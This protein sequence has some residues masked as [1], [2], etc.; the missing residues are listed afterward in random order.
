MLVQELKRIFE[1]RKIEMNAR[2]IPDDIK[3]L[4]VIHPRDMLEDTEYAIDQFVLRGGKLIAF[5]DPYAYFDQQPDMQNPFGGNQAGPVHVLQPVQGLGHRRRTWARS[6]RISPIASGAG[7]RLLPTLLNLNNQAL[8]M[9]DVVTSQVGTLLIPF[10]GAFKGK[11]A[12]G[13]T[14]DGARRTLRRTRCRWTSSSPRC[15]ASPRRAASSPPARRCR[16]RSGSPA[17]SSTAFPEG[18]PQAADA[19]R[20]EGCEEGRRE[21][22]GGRAAPQGSPPRRTRWCW[23]PTWTCSPTARRSRCRTYSGSAWS[24]PRNGNLAFAQGLVEQFSGDNALISL[25]SRAS[26]SRPLTLIREMEDRAQQSYLGKIKELEDSLNQTQE[27]LQSLQKAQERRRRARYSR[28]EQQAEIENF[29]KKAA[30]TRRDLKELR[31]NLRVETDTLEFWTK[32]FNIGLV[33]LLVALAGIILALSRRRR[34]EGGCSMN[35]K[36]FLIL[37]IVAARAGRRR[38]RAVLAGHRGLSRERRE[39][40]R[41]AP[42]Q[43][44]ARR[45]RPGAAPGRE[46]A[47]HARAQGDRLGRAGARR[48]SRPI[49]QEISDLM[50]KL[51][52]AEGDAVRAGRRIAAAAGRAERARARRRKGDGVG[53]LVE[54]KDAQASRSRGSFSARSC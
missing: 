49:S 53:T 33:P 8:N 20:E 31:K 13:L 54:F 22:G 10:G 16:S 32:V 36:Q 40:R 46:D 24:C 5:V 19:A 44:Q 12:E 42:A 37:V 6:S 35:R 9:D 25:R 29:R 4:L 17:S 1:V 3:V 48:L 47:D 14:H 21:E 50:V 2:S 43:V 15:R 38:H 27:K 51:V 30:E 52:G 18:R 7:P 34:A 41:A 11:P 28:A 39:D 26:F 45:R 23:S